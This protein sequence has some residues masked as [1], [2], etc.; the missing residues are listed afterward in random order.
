M[1]SPATTP[2]PS[3]ESPPVSPRHRQDILL[4]TVLCSFLFAY[5]G[6][7]LAV[8]LTNALW[9]GRPDPS[10]DTSYIG[11]LLADESLRAEIIFAIK[12]SVV[13]SLI[14]AVLGLIIG[15]PTA[16][17]L[18]RFKLPAMSVIDTVIDLPIVIPPLIGG[19]ALLLFFR[20]SALGLFLD[21]HL[22]IVYTQTGI[23]VA[24]FFVASAFSIRALKATFDQINPRF[25]GVARSLG[26][27]AWQAMWKVTL[28]LARTG[29][30]AGFVMTWARALGEFGPIMML[31]SASPG[32][33]AVLPV[34][35]FLNMSSGNVE[36][37]IAIVV[38][39][40]LIA[41]GTLI[42]FKRLGG[43]G[44]IW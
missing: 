35:A 39:M 20:Q 13:T 15:I 41:A 9:L 43:Q 2:G 26:C 38:L 33:T 34:S 4:K 1:S 29:M 31:A 6:I 5:M 30:I 11:S 3:V 23:V 25:E 7:I 36:G 17:A 44:Y 8:L 42:L 40:V 16:Y 18:S 28:P 24:Q 12:L 10:S 37:A 19:V 14:T 21:H 27:S 22:G 32:H